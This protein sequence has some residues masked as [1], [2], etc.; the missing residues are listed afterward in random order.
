MLITSHHTLEEWN[1]FN[2]TNQRICKT[3]LGIG[4]RNVV[5]IAVVLKK[6]CDIIDRNAKLDEQQTRIK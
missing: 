1:F 2:G 3:F 6:E 5:G 4:A